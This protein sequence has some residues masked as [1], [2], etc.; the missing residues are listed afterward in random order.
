[1]PT[2]GAH[3]FVLLN[4]KTVIVC[5][6]SVEYVLNETS[7]EKPVPNIVCVMQA[8]RASDTFLSL[9][10]VLFICLVFLLAPC[11]SSF[12]SSPTMR[13]QWYK[14]LCILLRFD[15]I[16]FDLYTRAHTHT[17]TRA[18]AH[19]CTHTSGCLSLTK[20]EAPSFGFH[21]L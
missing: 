1:M 14:N 18:H 4:K 11:L 20:G 8:D 9:V 3:P 12:T 6:S 2:T 17:H 7:G 21:S 13:R 10:V 5:P 19:T 16:V 15:L